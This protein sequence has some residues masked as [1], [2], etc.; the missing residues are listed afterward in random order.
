MSYLSD[1]SQDAHLTDRSSISW[2]YSSAWIVTSQRQSSAIT[3]KL[4]VTDAQATGGKRIAP[5]SSNTQNR[6]SRNLD[7]GSRSHRKSQHNL[8]VP[9]CSYRSVNA[10]LAKGNVSLECLLA[11]QTFPSARSHLVSFCASVSRHASASEGVC[12]L[13]QA[14]LTSVR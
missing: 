5:Q 12:L 9:I 14:R 13:L 7:E 2:C 1:L 8:D 3:R 6:R 4:P 10:T 11:I